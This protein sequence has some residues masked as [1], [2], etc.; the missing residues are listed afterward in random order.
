MNV[1]FA[2]KIDNEVFRLLEDF[3]KILRY[4][5][6]LCSGIKVIDNR[7]YLLRNICINQITD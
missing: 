1:N 7:E 3:E 2:K 6:E 5:Y 4:I